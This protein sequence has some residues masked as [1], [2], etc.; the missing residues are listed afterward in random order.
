MYKEEVRLPRQVRTRRWKLGLSLHPVVER[1]HIMAWRHNR[2]GEEM[3]KVTQTLLGSEVGNCFAACIASMF[4]LTIDEVP[5]F[6]ADKEMWWRNLQA[7]L[8][9]M[10]LAFVELQMPEDKMPPLPILS[11]GMLCLATGKG[12]RGLMHAIVVRYGTDG[13]MHWLDTAH[14][15]HPSREAL[16]ETRYLGWFIVLDPSKPIRCKALEEV[17][18]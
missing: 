10:N 18:K 16:V 12:P 9:P 13:T 2:R 6:C 1:L 3:K 5:N 14:D 4:E 17:E 15:P 11:D 8:K 7:W